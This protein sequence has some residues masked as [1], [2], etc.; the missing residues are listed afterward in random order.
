M[1][2]VIVN[3]VGNSI[4]NP[5]T[6]LSVSAAV[7]NTTTV[8]ITY[9]AIHDNGSTILPLVGSGTDTGDITDSTGTAVN[10]TY[11]GTLSRAGGVIAVT[12]SFPVAGTYTFS[13]RSRNAA[14]VSSY[15]TTSTGIIPAPPAFTP[16]PSFTPPP[17]FTLPPQSFTPP[18]PSFT[19]PGPTFTLP[20]SFSPGTV[21]MYKP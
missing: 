9:G 20:P 19:P 17:T 1:A 16:P 13:I 7:V 12:G 8:N 15:I 10:L 21:P 5:S 6:P 2:G 4:A 11:S 3:L 18:P 14:G